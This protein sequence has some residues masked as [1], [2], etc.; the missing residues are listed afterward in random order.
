MSSPFLPPGLR[1]LSC[2]EI[3]SQI[4]GENNIVLVF[5]RSGFFLEGNK[6][7]VGIPK[8]ERLGFDSP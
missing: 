3:R 4:T 5:S 1:R 6:I 2:D 7:V 8:E